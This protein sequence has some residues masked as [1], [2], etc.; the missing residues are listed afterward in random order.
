M[1]QRNPFPPHWP[2]DHVR[3]YRKWLA[4][5]RAR[6]SPHW[7]TGKHPPPKLSDRDR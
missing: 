4:E 5:E 2:E 6:D 3:L 1:I 7:M